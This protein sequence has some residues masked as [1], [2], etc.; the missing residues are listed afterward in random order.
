MRYAFGP[1]VLSATLIAAAGGVPTTSKPEE[2]GMSAER[3]QR[4]HEAV[5][6]HIDAKDVSGAVAL[7]ATYCR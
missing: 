3:L 1:V 2:V 5:A 4:I 7:V 6:K